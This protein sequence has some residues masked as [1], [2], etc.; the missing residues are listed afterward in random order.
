MLWKAGRLRWLARPGSVLLLV[1]PEFESHQKRISVCWEKK[2]PS[3]YSPQDLAMV[4]SV[5]HPGR[6]FLYQLLQFQGKLYLACSCN[7]NGH[8]KKNSRNCTGYLLLLSAS[9]LSLT[10]RGN[11]ERISACQLPTSTL[12]DD[13]DDFSTSQFIVQHA[14]ENPSPSTIFLC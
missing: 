10:F 4:E 3:L 6:V 1:G 9:W 5:S 12:S 13:D 7:S 11:D 8:N 2:N 14:K